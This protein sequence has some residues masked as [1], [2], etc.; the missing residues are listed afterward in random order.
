MLKSWVSGGSF[1]IS[2]DWSDE[3]HS[4]V[5]DLLSKNRFDV[6]HAVRPN[7]F[8]Y[9][10]E[11]TSNYTV[12]D[13][14]NV[15]TQVVRRTFES[16][17]FT[18]SG[19]LSLFES[20]RLEEYERMAC[21]KA[22][23]VLTVTDEDNAALTALAT[24]AA[25][26]VQSTPIKTV[27][28]G[29]DTE[30]FAYSWQPHPD[31][32]SLFVGTMYWPP[33]V[34]CVTYYC[35]DILPLI[36]KSIR[37]TQ[38]DIVGLRP[39]RAVIDLEKRVAGIHV[40]GSV[41]DVR[42]YMSRSRVLVVPLRAGSGM[43]VKILNAMAVGVPVVTTSIGCE[44]ISGLVPVAKPTRLDANREANIWIA[45]S[46]EEFSEAVVTLIRDDELAST[47][48][49]NGRKLMLQRY[50]WTIIR[51]EILRI[52]DRIERDLGKRRSV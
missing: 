36:R 32:R 37:A 22:D 29:V 5:A 16:K 49:R 40:S 19:L 35:R 50:D 8:Q 1:I 34:D 12:L 27:P 24:S 20:K 46:P 3:F 9:V 17:P 47:I 33:N 14:E 30:Y 7:M 2:R 13:T 23:L 52:Y 11:N 43:R 51:Q 41:D 4:R 28:I 25:G 39:A 42:P 26:D 38:F 31:P 15:E 48:S 45:D 18:L 10:P 44:G 6:I 21:A